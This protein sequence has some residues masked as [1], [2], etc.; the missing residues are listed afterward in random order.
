KIKFICYILQGNVGDSRAVASVGG[1][2]Q[3]LS[4]DHKP[5]NESETKRIIA[6]G[7][8]V[9]FNRVNG[10]LA[11]SR[12]LGDFVF[13][14]NDKKPPEEQIVTAYPD[15]VVREVTPDHEFIVLACD[16]IW[17]VL[18]NE[19]VVDFIRSRV[20]AKMEPEQVNSFNC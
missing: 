9:E 10:N 20:A 19:D 7:G 6:A 13:K 4:F 3:Q 2:V 17:D 14:K 15:V 8:W 18:S 16:G 12:A 11:L 1:R 5:S